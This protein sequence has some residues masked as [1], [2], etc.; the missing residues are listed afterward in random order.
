MKIS[1]PG[2]KSDDVIDQRGA[3]AGRAGGLP[4]TALAGMGIPGIIIIVVLMLLG[5]GGV[6]G[7]GGGGGGFGVDAPFDTAPAPGDAPGAVP[8]APDPEAETVEFVSFVLDDIQVSWTDAFAASNQRYEDAKLVL[9]TTGVESG[10]GFAPSSTGPFYCPA[11]KRVYL[12]LGFFQELAGRF[13]APGDFAQAYVIAHEIGHHI[14]NITGISDEVRR[15]QQQ[16]P[17]DANELSIRLELQADC[18]AGVWGY[19][20]YQRG[21]LESGDVEEGLAAAAAVGDDR[22]QKEATGR[23]NQDTWTHGSSEQ[24]QKWFRRGFESGDASECD[25]FDGDI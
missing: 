10:C 12:D 24:R 13:N 3:P 8:G 9:F 14:Q 22:I 4:I 1:F 2:R 19:T 15:L 23:I 20:T 11:D 6:P 5:G 21:I 16:N 25:T 18:L 7:T 17:D